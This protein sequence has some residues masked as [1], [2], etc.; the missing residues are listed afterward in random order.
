MPGMSGEL[1]RP[2]VVGKVIE[3]GYAQTVTRDGSTVYVDLMR[4]PGHVPPSGDGSGIETIQLPEPVTAEA[5]STIVIRFSELPGPEVA[6][7]SQPV[8]LRD[9][10]TVTSAVLLL[11]IDGGYPAD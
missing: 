9:G 2:G 8:F 1:E 3:G 7:E 10:M 5:G 4:V 11:A 6:A